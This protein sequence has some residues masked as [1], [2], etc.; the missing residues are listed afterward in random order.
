MAHK[1]EELVKN[2]FKAFSTGDMDLFHSITTDDLIMN[3]PGTTAVAGDYFGRDNVLAM[4][5]ELGRITEGSLKIEGVN[6][7]LANDDIGVAF[8][9]CSAIRHG[10]RIESMVAEKYTIRDGKISEIRAYVYDMPE[11]DRAYREE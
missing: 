8:F 5:G 7:I 2:F 9:D 1:N 11:W 3:E 4:F 6:H 10:E